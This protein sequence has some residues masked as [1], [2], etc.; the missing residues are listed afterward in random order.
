MVCA[1]QRHGC[2]DEGSHLVGD[3]APDQPVLGRGGELSCDAHNE[4]A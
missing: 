3:I 4:Q 1:G 2:A